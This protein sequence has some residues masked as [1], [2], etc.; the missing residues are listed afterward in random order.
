MVTKVKR[1]GNS[2]AIRIPRGLASEVPI[3]EDTE[4]DLRAENG[5]LVIRLATPRRR[6]KYRL[7]DLVVQITPDNVHEEI[8]KGPPVGNEV[9]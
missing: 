1:W 7:D 2:L 4:I 5:R 3:G 8:P 6:P 9:W